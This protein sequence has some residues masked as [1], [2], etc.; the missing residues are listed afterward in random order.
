MQ[1]RMGISTWRSKDSMEKTDFSIW[2]KRMKVILVHVKVAKALERKQ[3]LPSTIATEEKEEI[4]ERAYS[5]IILHLSDR[6]LRSQ[7]S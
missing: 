6:V 7:T 3:N 1:S 2:R 5:T 4:M